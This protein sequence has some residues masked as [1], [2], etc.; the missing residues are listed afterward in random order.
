MQG[1][2]PSLKKMFFLDFDIIMGINATF[3]MHWFQN[4]IKFCCAVSTSEDIGKNM[5][6]MLK[7]PILWF[8]AHY[9]QFFL[10]IYLLRDLPQKNFI[11]IWNQCTKMVKL[12]P[13]MSKSRKNIFLREGF[14]L[15]TFFIKKIADVSILVRFSWSIPFLNQKDLCNKKTGGTY[16]YFKKL[17]YASP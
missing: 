5:P 17:F 8:L 11:Q 15:C 12:I 2:D 16:W 6:K 4:C 1:G 7:L 3:L 9:W 10:P 13:M 14:L